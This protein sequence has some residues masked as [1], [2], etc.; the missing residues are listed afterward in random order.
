MA[1]HITTGAAIKLKIE[2]TESI[3]IVATRFHGRYKMNS[4]RLQSDP[5]GFRKIFSILSFSKKYE[6]MPTNAQKGMN[7]TMANIIR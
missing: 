4:K 6:N 7:R 3:T 5:L 1:G 2:H